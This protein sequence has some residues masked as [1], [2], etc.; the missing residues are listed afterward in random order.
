MVHAEGLI[1]QVDL[2]GNSLFHNFKDLYICTYVHNAYICT[3]NSLHI[4][5]LFTENPR[6]NDVISKN[7]HIKVRFLIPNIISF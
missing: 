5:A 6:N 1:K 7:E 4:L 2:Y 3:H